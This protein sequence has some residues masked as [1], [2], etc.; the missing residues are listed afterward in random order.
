MRKSN[1]IIIAIFLLFNNFIFLN[2]QS[3]ITNSIVVKVGESVIT[4][5]DVEN[6]IITNLIINKQEINQQNINQ[7]KDFAVKNLIM[8]SIKR[9]EIKKYEIKRY[10]QKELKNYI[11]KT[12]SSFDTDQKGL[13]K[14]F[15][16]NKINF[17]QFIKNYETELLWNTLIFQIYKNQT[18]VNIVEVKNEVSNIGKGKTEEEL[19]KIRETII[20]QKKQEKLSLFS[21]S[22]FSNLENSISINF[23]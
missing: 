19:K 15:E 11:N 8:K 4:S 17:Q 12:A 3:K 13:K 21:R 6:E 7:I 5:I 22:H 2:L 10:D 23:Q 16:Q 14:V 9:S 18:N 20:N 1:L